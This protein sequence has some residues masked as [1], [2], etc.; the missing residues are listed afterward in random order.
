MRTKLKL[1]QKAQSKSSIKTR[2]FPKKLFLEPQK[3]K[4]AKNSL[5]SGI[6]RFDLKSLKKYWITKSINQ[7][8]NFPKKSVFST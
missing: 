7:N 2:N 1:N 4:G 8:E 5:P 6:S 3:R